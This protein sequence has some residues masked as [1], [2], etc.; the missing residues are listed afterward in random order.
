M[1]VASTV[2]DFQIKAGN[3]LNNGL[4]VYT[5]ET[6]ALLLAVQWVEGKKAIMDNNL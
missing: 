1:G 4:S 2:P 3:R 6:L 5:G